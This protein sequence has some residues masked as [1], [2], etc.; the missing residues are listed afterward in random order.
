VRIVL[1]TN[2]VVSGLLKVSGVSARVL[3]LA[4]QGDVVTLLYDDRIIAEYLEVLARKGLDPIRIQQVIESLQAVG[5]PVMAKAIAVQSPDPDDQMFIEV[6]AAGFADAIVTGNAKH[7]PTDCG[8]PILSPAEFLR[9][10]GN[11]PSERAE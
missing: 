4:Q 11:P 8:A 6:A 1:D 2:V 10:M 9:M 7:F 3:E 5:E